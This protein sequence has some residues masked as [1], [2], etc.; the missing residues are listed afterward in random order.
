MTEQI[1]TPQATEVADLARQLV[2][3]AEKNARE[4]TAQ[5]L[6]NVLKEG[7]RPAPPP[8]PELP[9]LEEVAHREHSGMFDIVALLRAAESRIDECGG[10]AD[11][12]TDSDYAH[13]TLRLLQ[14]ARERVQQ[15]QRAFDPYI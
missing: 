15:A 13:D 9:P 5:R 1:V 4:I 2:E 7:A 12:R 14:L 10:L 6:L 3:S 11:F 8:P